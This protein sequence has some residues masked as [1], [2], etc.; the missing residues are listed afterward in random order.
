MGQLNG[1]L[2]ARLTSARSRAFASRLPAVLLALSAIVGLMECQ[3]QVVEEAIDI[4]GIWTESGAFLEFRE[5]G[6]FSLSNRVEMI[7]TSRLLFGDY[8]IEGNV[9]TFVSSE[10]SVDCHGITAT[11]EVEL[12]QE[13][14]LKITDLDNPC[15]NP[16]TDPETLTWIRY[17]P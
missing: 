3:S 9:L 15:A 13:G 5:D 10:E 8:E 6:T 1:A 11:F 12:T 2:S 16:S 17:S 14:E 4:V 7:D